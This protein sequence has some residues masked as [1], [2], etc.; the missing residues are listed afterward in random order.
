MLVQ[1]TLLGLVCTFA[2]LHHRITAPSRFR[3]IA[4]ACIVNS[5]NTMPSAVEERKAALFTSLAELRKRPTRDGR[6]AVLRR[7]AELEALRVT[8]A[9][10]DGR[11]A[12]IFSTQ[13]AEPEARSKA[14]GAM[15]FVQPLV[16]ATYATFFKF[17]PALAGAQ[18]DGG[19][20]GGGSNEQRLSLTTNLVENRVRIP[21]PSGLPAVGGSSLEIFVDGEVEAADGGAGAA[22]ETKE[23]L[24]VA[25][26]EFSVR[27]RRRGGSDGE[28]AGAVRLPLP[29]PVGSLR[30]SFCDEGLRVSRGG[31]GGVFVLR[32]LRDDS[33]AAK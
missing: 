20:G 28:R 22:G 32:R 1:A 29:R 10:P 17:I 15:P 7:V 13:L 14:S 24:R 27:L 5:D 6:D 11:W 19:A 9:P 23:L 16:D 21:L 8:T 3:I 26:T 31:R 12:L 18:P 2:P 25:F 30:T 33:G 4:P